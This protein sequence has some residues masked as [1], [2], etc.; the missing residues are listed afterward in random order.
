MCKAQGLVCSCAA[1]AP[2]P[3]NDLWDPWAGLGWAAV[4]L[5]TAQHARQVSKAGASMQ[6]WAGAPGPAPCCLSIEA[7]WRWLGSAMRVKRARFTSRRSACL[8]PQQQQQCRLLFAIWRG[9]RRGMAVRLQSRWR[10]TLRNFP[11]GRPGG[12]SRGLV[13]RASMGVRHLVSHW[14]HSPL[15]CS[16]PPKICRCR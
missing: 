9:G 8:Q 6:S 1:A 11:C 13:R 5:Q 4:R 2:L 12:G 10:G 16:M 14:P 7:G 15:H 3:R